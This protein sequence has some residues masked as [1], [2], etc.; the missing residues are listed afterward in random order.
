MWLHQRLMQ[1]QPPAN[2][3][4]AVK[5]KPWPMQSEPVHWPWKM[6]IRTI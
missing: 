1:P 6:A 2:E 4:V 5:V 3:S